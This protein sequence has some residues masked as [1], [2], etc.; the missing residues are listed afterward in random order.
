ML[1]DAYCWK[2]LSLVQRAICVI[3]D[4]FQ[5][6]FYG[7]FTACIARYESSYKEACAC[8]IMCMPEKQAGRYYSQ[9]GELLR[10]QRFSFGC[11]GQDVILHQT[12]P[13]RRS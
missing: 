2:R 1:T 7:R 12:Q 8:K 9:V 11:L 4:A 10:R 5:L 3:I 13:E 6:L